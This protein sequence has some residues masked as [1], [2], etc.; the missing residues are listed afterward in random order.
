MSICSRETSPWAFNLI[1]DF[2]RTIPEEDNEHV[3]PVTLDS[4]SP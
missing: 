2:P 3:M 1:S 4:P